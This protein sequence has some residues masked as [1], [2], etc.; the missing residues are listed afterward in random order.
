MNIIVDG[1]G[2]DKGTKEIVKGCVE[3]VN[4]LGINIIIVGKKDII[5]E[6]LIKY[7][8]PKEAID[9]INATETIFNDEEPSLAIRR[10]RTLQ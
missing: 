7:E 1:M 8:F 6:E 2:G 3:A 5:E 10:K 4:Q 9:I